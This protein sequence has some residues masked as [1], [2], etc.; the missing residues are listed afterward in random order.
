[1]IELQI[2]QIIDAL[3]QNF[4]LFFNYFEKHVILEGNQKAIDD[5]P[6]AV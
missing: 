1:V 4:E 6:H 2:M 3:L 5:V